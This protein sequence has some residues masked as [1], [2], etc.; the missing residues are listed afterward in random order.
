LK[1]DRWTNIRRRFEHIRGERLIG[2]PGSR[3]RVL[4]ESKILLHQVTEENYDAG[5]D[6]LCDGGINME[7]LDK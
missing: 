3:A 1:V 2:D 5:S 4:L 6:D 7:Y